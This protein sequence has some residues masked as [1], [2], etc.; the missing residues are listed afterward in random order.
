MTNLTKA[1]KYTCVLWDNRSAQHYAIN[2]YF[3]E[4]REMHRVAVHD[5][6][7]D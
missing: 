2:D 6:T 1:L 5:D 4:R 7:I 3:G